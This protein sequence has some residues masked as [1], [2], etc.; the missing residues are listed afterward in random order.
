MKIVS[1][2][3]ESLGAVC[4]KHGPFEMRIE[5]Y[6]LG[7]GFMLFEYC[8]KCA[9]IENQA[10]QKRAEAYKAEREA[11]ELANRKREAGLRKRH[12]NC[13]FDNYRVTTPAQQRALSKAQG[14][15]TRFLDDD[16]I[17]LVMTGKVGTGKT[18]LAA[19]IISKLIDEKKSCELI[20]L[21]EVIRLIKAS[22]SDSTLPSESK[23]IERYARLDLLVLDEVGV[24]YGSDTEKLLISEIIDN[25]YQEMKPTVL[26]SNLDINGVRACIGDRCYD[27]LRE[28]GGE[29]IRFDWDSFRGAA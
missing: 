3:P 28:D 11:E 16:P 21:P 14:F 2:K 20:K 18:H 15:L 5:P 26:I 25:R 4:E 22:W 24:Q 12:F 8:P 19:A 17:N 13:S 1:E 23:I 9:A 10:E 29:S 7:K 6:P 27:R